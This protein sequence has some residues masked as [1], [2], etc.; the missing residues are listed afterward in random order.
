[1]L[2]LHNFKLY[3]F[4]FYNLA[5]TISMNLVNTILL[6]EPMELKHI[7]YFNVVCK[8]KNF[9]KAA[10][11][12]FV[13][14]QAVS[15]KIK[16][17]EYELSTVLFSRHHTG[18]EL[19]EEGSYFYTQ[20]AIMLQTQQEILM[21]FALLSMEKRQGLQVGISHGLNIFFNRPFFK[22]FEQL[23]P[24]TS[25]HITELWNPQ[26][27]DDVLSGKI[28]VGFTL[29]PIKHSQ[30]HVQE[31]FSEPLCCI[32]NTTHPLAAKAFLTIEDILD[33]EIVMADDNYNSYHNFIQLC[34]QYG[35]HP[36]TY[37]VPDLMS[38]YEH[39]LHDN[40]VGFSLESLSEIM[41][42]N[43]IQHIPLK[44]FGARWNI[45]LIWNYDTK[46]KEH[47]GQFAEY[48][49]EFSENRHK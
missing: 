30:L 22:K 23:H 32:V 25:L 4:L 28:D 8:Y 29:A 13:T 19:T 17:L 48:V 14:Q 44:D 5:G 41:H 34:E 31:L 9:S 24:S 33:E 26:I 45:C 20:A 35:K 47:I 7:Q 38:I 42:F 18:V 39:C 10:N 11:E 27:E 49:I 16:E 40:V 37:P 46:K 6:E 12:L 15:K 3:F 43:N 1:M 2:S 36:K 21:H